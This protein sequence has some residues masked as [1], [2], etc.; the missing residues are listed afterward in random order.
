MPFILVLVGAINCKS[1]SLTGNV[2]II[3]TG[4]KMVG[5]TVIIVGGLVFIFKGK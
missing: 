3:F 4:A 1:V 2:N 5:L